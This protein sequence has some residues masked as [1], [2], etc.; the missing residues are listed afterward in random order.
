MFSDFIFYLRNGIV[1]WGESCHGDT[2]FV[3]DEFCEVPFY[4]VAQKTTLFGL[5]EFEQGVSVAPIDVDLA[6]L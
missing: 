2:V 6:E 4:E 3:D 5:Q 1:K